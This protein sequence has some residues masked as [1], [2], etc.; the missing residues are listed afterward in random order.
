M[1]Q[2]AN[3][4]FI[5]KQHHLLG[6]SI[7]EIS[8][9]TGYS[10][11][12][13][14]KALTFTEIPKYQLT[15]PKSCP[16]SDPVKETVQQWLRHDGLMPV[17]QRHTAKRIFDRLVAEY[18]FQGGESTVRHLVRTLKAKPPEAYVPLEFPPGAFA[19]FDWGEAHISC[20]GKMMKVQL[21]CM[22]LANSRKFFVKAFPHQ[23]QEALLQGHVDAFAYFGAVPK[24]ITYDNLK[25]VVKRI[26]EGSSREEQELFI[27]LRAHYLFDSRFCE[28]A[29]GNQKGQVEHLVRYA[30]QNFLVPMPEVRSLDELN[31][32]LLAAC[33]AFEQHPVPRTG[34]TVGERFDQERPFML[35]LPTQP[36]PCCRTVSVKSNSLSMVHFDRNAYSVPVTHAANSRL[37]LKA[38]VNRIEIYEGTERLAT[39]DRCYDKD[40]EILD[41][42]HYLDLLLK[43]PGAVLYARTLHLQELPPIY[44]DLL[45]LWQRRAG[46]LKDFVR[47]LLLH[48]EYDRTLVEEALIE[49]RRRNMLQVDAIVQLLHQRTLP[50][51]R[52]PPLQLPPDSSIPRV[53][54]TQPN[55]RQYNE[56]TKRSMV[57]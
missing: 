30:R 22:R 41:Y 14:R 2:M 48:R 51:H 27:Q 12:V 7:R 28:P 54:V 37:W 23:K 5:K 11:Q 13:I 42:D 50:Q 3:Y 6:K 19:Q 53:T 4:E 43:R 34:Q 35:P 38:F 18:G 57:H 49:A 44:Q 36:L 47:V 46:G 45:L 9:E 39:H 20:G 8:R 10:R 24:T 17:K 15:K 16:V 52:I 29:K 40:Q 1:L 55:L 25:T 26:L 21:F 31:V 32:H 33:D 56:L